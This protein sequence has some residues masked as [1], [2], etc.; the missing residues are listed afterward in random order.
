MFNFNQINDNQKINNQLAQR[1][2]E[3]CYKTLLADK[4]F[5]RDTGHM[6]DEAL[7][8]E[9]TEYGFNIFIHNKD[10]NRGAPYQFYLEY[11]TSP[12]LIHFAFGKPISVFH[13]GSTKHVG[14][15]SRRAYSVV[16]N[17]ILKET[18]GR[19]VYEKGENIK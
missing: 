17:A 10:V 13:P 3:V 5:P 1:L 2:M 14:F 16:A 4:Q 11:G 15:W 18:N 19:R 7:D 12:H 8:V 6:Q 9:I